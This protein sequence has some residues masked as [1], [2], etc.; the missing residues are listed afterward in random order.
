MRICLD[1]GHGTK[2]GIH[3][4]ARGNGIVEDQ[5]CQSFCGRLGHYLR[6]NGAEVVFTR[7]NSNI[8]N[9]KDRPKIAKRNKCDVFLSIH[10][11]AAGSS[12]AHG[13]EAF[14]VPGDG[15]SQRL[16][17]K[18][19]TV[20][21]SAGMHFRGVK[22]DNASQYKSLAVLR[23]TYSVMPAVLL[24]VGFVSNAAD[25]ARLKDARWVEDLAC[26]MAKVLVK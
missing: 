11:N 19:C 14:V 12:Q 1:A 18:L 23:D 20:M 3:T 16:A 15:R 13:C 4:G 2:Q 25:A 17:A 9:L 8:V 26:E 5:W 6:A 10:L 22:P 21:F 7:L 24:E